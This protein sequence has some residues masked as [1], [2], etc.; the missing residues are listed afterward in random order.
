MMDVI[1]FLE[2]KSSIWLKSNKFFISSLLFIFVLS[3]SILSYHTD[4]SRLKI[5]DQYLLNFKSILKLE[6]FAINIVKNDIVI[7]RLLE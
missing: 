5:L 6:K 7:S 1:N 2:Q 3:F 4:R